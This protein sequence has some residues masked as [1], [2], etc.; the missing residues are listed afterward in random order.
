MVTRVERERKLRDTGIWGNFCSVTSGK[1]DD[2]EI[3]KDYVT[4]RNNV[5]FLTDD[6]IQSVIQS[7]DKKEIMRRIPSS[8][9]PFFGP[10]RKLGKL[11]TFYKSL[12]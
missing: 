12:R 1:D 6:E 11:I 5:K 7:I 2:E 10:A 4:K 3:A 9:A 8:P